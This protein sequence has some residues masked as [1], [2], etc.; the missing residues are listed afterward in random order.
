MQDRFPSLD[1]MV[2]S[3]LANPAFDITVP[4]NVRNAPRAPPVTVNAQKLADGVFWLTGGTHHSLAIKM[5]DHIVLVDTPNGEARALAV[6]AKAKEV[7]PGKPI[8]YVVA[9]HHHWDHLGGI[10]TAIDEGATIIS[11]QTNKV[12]L[13]R[14]AKAPHTI[15]PDR[16]SIS[17]K[18]LKLQTVDSE[19]TLTDGQRTIKLYTMI[20]FDHTGD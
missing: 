14:A 10:R 5:K 16:L 15:N 3:A 13:E 9:L 2:T 18:L 4:D 7:I 6:I 19:S 20:G 12:F 1:L 17:K 8:R 11:H